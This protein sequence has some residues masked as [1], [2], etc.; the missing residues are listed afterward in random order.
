MGVGEGIGVLVCGG[1]DGEGVGEG[2]GGG[3]EVDDGETVWLAT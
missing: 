2:E 1:M 3:E